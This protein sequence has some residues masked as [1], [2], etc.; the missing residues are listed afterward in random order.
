MTEKKVSKNY[1]SPPLDTRSKELRR[2]IVRALAGGERGHMGSSMSLV[3]IIRVLYDNFLKFR[4]EDPKWEGRDRF[5]LSKGHG[6]LAHYAI[7]ADKGFLALD[8]LDRF[9]HNDGILGGHPDH[10]KIP[11]VEASTGALGHGLSIGVGIALAINIK[12][13]SQ[14]VIVVTGDGEINEGSVWEAA[15]C[16]GN[17]Q[18]ENLTVLVDYNKIQSYSFTKDVADLEPLVKKWEAFGFAVEEI[19]G[20]NVAQLQSVV[21]KLPFH[22]NKPSAIICHTIKGK[23]FDFAENRPEWHHKS[24]LSEEEIQT[25]LTCLEV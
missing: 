25:L 11:G 1:N 24:N 12:R 23:G 3:E 21:K 5:I 4:P 20:H 19:D 6:C 7:L 9:C 13:E 18:L 2:L 8:E 17:H 22:L 16:A 15:M 10:I 14:R